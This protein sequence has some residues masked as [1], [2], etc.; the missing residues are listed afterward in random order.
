M[1]ELASVVPSV[2]VVFLDSMVAESFSKLVTTAEGDASFV[3]SYIE[4]VR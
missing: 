2:S 1:S 4:E 3:N